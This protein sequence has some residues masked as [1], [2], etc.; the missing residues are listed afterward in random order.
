MLHILLSFITILIFSI[1]NT[2]IC[3]HVFFE[4]ETA[5]FHNLKITVLP[6]CSPNSILCHFCN[7]DID[8]ITYF[9]IQSCL[10]LII[11]HDSVINQTFDDIVNILNRSSCLR[12][13]LASTRLSSWDATVCEFRLRFRSLG[14]C[15]NIERWPL[16]AWKVFFFWFVD[17]HSVAFVIVCQ[18]VAIF[19][20]FKTEAVLLLSP[21]L[22]G[23]FLPLFEFLSLNNLCPHA[24]D[25]Y[26]QHR[27]R[28]LLLNLLIYAI[29]RLL[30]Q[31]YSLEVIVNGRAQI[32]CNCSH[33]VFGFFRSQIWRRGHSQILS[34][35][36]KLLFSIRRF[37]LAFESEC[38]GNWRL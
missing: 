27:I 3:S 36:W 7:A 37:L 4:I 17:N 24:P 26:V 5:N 15:W 19:V 21:L 13:A 18:S 38:A 34:R 29:L 22:L 2:V 14:T 23:Q 31:I 28:K 10:F 35:T 8:S 33:H 6:S 25:I 12:L 9:E 30:H 20:E 16:Q 32:Y 11:F 1:R